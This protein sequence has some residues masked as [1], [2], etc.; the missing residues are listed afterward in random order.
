MRHGTAA[1]EN[2]VGVPQKIKMIAPY[3]LCGFSVKQL[4]SDSINLLTTATL[5]V[6]MNLSEDNTSGLPHGKM[7][8]NHHMGCQHF[9]LSME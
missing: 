3:D 1:M 7:Q 6:I 2:R 4:I 9:L 8:Y 5:F